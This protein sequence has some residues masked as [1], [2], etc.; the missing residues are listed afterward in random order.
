MDVA[1]RFGLEQIPNVIEL[2][3]PRPVQALLKARGPPEGSFS[4]RSQRLSAK[5][6][7]VVSMRFGLEGADS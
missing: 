4:L 2:H 7:G 6:E 1:A 5:L 3:D